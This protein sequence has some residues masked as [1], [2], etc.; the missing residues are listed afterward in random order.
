MKI[1]KTLTVL[2]VLA[3]TVSIISCEN[4]KDKEKL[5]KFYQS[6]I[7]FYKSD[8]FKTNIL[9]DAYVENKKGKIIYESG[10]ESEEDYTEIKTKLLK[11]EEIQKLAFEMNTAMVNSIKEELRITRDKLL[12]AENKLSKV[13]LELDK[14]SEEIEKTLDKDKE[15]KESEAKE[16]EESKVPVE[17]QNDEK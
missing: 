9:D 7:E 4:S 15:K 13:V 2:F 10:F 11:D 3:V 1:Y 12:T 6:S 16:K 17:E 5:V 14:A 8:E